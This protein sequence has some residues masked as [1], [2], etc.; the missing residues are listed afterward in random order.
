[1]TLRAA[2][3][4]AHELRAS[5]RRGLPRV[6][7]RRLLLRRRWPAP[8]GRRRRSARRPVRRLGSIRLTLPPS[9][10]ATQTAPRPTATSAGPRPT[11]IGA[12]VRRVLGSMRVTV[13]ARRLDT[14]TPPPPTASP[15]APGTVAVGPGRP[16]AAR[17]VGPHRPVAGGDPDGARSERRRR[18]DRRRRDAARRPRRACADRS[19]PASGAMRRR[20]RSRRRRPPPRSDC[21]RRRSAA[22]AVA[23]DSGCPGRG[24]VSGSPE[25]ISTIAI[26]AA[27][28]V[29]AVRISKRGGIVAVCAV[30]AL[31][32]S[33][34]RFARQPS[35]QQASAPARASHGPVS[36]L[37][38]ER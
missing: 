9:A 19:W 31:R 38:P 3:V 37:R 5:R 11:R 4:D 6:R 1:M 12:P 26:V 15:L 17:I 29:R 20:P 23:G 8:G 16:D 7:P 21:R 34:S 13:P 18:T 33:L 36:S 28:S 22:P 2:G 35:R 25:P 30:R 27:T 10:L 14:H 32:R 24:A